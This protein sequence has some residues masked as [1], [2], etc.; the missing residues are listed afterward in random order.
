MT[1]VCRLVTSLLLTIGLVFLMLIRVIGVHSLLLPMSITDLE[2]TLCFT[3]PP[4]L[5]YFCSFDANGR[6]VIC[7]WSET[8]T[9]TSLSFLTIGESG[10]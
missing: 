6:I 3:T 4:A 9:P 1:Y 2:G 5:F 10:E 7:F 8:V